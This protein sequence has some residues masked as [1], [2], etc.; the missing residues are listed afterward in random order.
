MPQL[1][2]F[3]FYI[4]NLHFSN[5]HSSGY[6]IVLHK[7][8]EL[9]YNGV[10]STITQYIQGV[11]EKI[12]VSTDAGFLNELLNQWNKHRTAICM[13]RDILMYMDRNYVP[14]HKKTVKLFLYKPKACLWV[15]Y[16]LWWWSLSWKH[17]EKDP[18]INHGYYQKRQ[19]WRRNC[20]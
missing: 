15:G 13:V 1:W 9:L 20:K 18:K 3:K 19:R 2:V 7:H 8:G 5:W 4:R 16:N 6:Q 11:R 17:F 14:Q 10:K 12:M